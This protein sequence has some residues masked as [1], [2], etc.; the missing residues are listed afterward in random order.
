MKQKNLQ[1]KILNEL[2]KNKT[3][4][5]FYLVNGFQLTGVVVSF[6]NFTILVNSSGKDQLIYKHAISTLIPEESVKLFEEEEGEN[7]KV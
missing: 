5:T 7:N 3:T 4:V 2:R 6:D 1:D